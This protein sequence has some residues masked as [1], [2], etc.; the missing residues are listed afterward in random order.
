MSFMTY[1]FDVN[2]FMARHQQLGG[3]H[4]TTIVETPTTMEMYGLRVITVERSGQ[5][6][7]RDELRNLTEHQW[8]TVAAT[9]RL[10][11]AGNTTV[12]DVV[13]RLVKLLPFWLGGIDYGEFAGEFAISR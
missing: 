8:D 11:Q 9:I 12:K 7:S 2:D 10:W 1:W 4:V 6:L 5:S 13:N 3:Y